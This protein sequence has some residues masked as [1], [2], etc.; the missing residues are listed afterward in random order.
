MSL[1]TL[2][3]VWFHKKVLRASDEPNVLM[4]KHKE[5]DWKSVM[6]FQEALL[7]ASKTRV[8]L[9]RDF[10]NAHLSLWRLSALQKQQRI[11]INCADKKA[12]NSIVVT[13][14]KVQ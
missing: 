1:S 2:Q 4:P 8:I 14:I 11:I 13:F 3:S 7:H 6:Q 10:R 9:T 5:Q 12:N